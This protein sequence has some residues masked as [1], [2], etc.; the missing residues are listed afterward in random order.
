LEEKGT[1][2]AKKRRVLI[3]EVHGKTEKE[4]IDKERKR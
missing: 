4:L 1:G 3:E 2:K